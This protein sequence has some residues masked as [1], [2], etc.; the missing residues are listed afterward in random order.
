MTYSYSD[1]TYEAQRFVHLSYHTEHDSFATYSPTLL[2]RAIKNRGQ[3]TEGEI[4]TYEYD[5]DSLTTYVVDFTV[6][7]FVLTVILFVVDVIIRKVKWA[8]I[9]TLF[10]KKR[11]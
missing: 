3:I 10:R 9:A 1:K 4:P 7:L 5:T 11:V 2:Y 6:P 8:D